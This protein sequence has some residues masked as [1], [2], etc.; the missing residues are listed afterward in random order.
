MA[1]SSDSNVSPSKRPSLAGLVQSTIPFSLV[2]TSDQEQV[3]QSTENMSASSQS[4]TAQSHKRPS[5]VSSQP[6]VDLNRSAEPFPRPTSLAVDSPNV[7]SPSRDRSPSE[8]VR[9]LR[10]SV[11]DSDSESSSRPPLYPRRPTGTDWNQKS[12][13]PIDSESD[14]VSF[15]EVLKQLDEQ[16]E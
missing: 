5:R 2:H 7:V 6:R 14:V 13:S 9:V 11:F 10:D 1:N 8:V 4:G 16:E 3:Q 12:R 15:H